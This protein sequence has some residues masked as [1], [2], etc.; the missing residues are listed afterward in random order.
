[1]LRVREGVRTQLLD[2][3]LDK[4]QRG[5]KDTDTPNGR[6]EHEAEYYNIENAQNLNCGYETGGTLGTKRFRK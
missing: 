3:R 4:M 5:R 6:K 2:V 1:M